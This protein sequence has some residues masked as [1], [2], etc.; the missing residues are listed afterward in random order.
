[1]GVIDIA[2]LACFLPAIV[3]GFKNGLVKQL[4]SILILVLGITLS[5]RFATTGAEFLQP[6]LEIDFKWLKII[7]F[8]VIF[9]LVALVLSLVEKLITKI[10]KIT[11]LGWVNHLLG[12]IL[13]IVEC[14]VILSLVVYFFDSVN[15]LIELL[16]QEKIAE[17]QLYSPMLELSRTVFP[18][19]K[20]LI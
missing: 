15:S 8:A 18:L 2:I 17:S 10:V 5:I 1:M 20:E 14:A 16:P 12:M 13:G 6:Y 4:I 9:I 11:L 7:S 3:L 19:L